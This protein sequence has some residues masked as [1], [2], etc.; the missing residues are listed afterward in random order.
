MDAEIGTVAA[1]FLFW[2]YLFRIFGIGSVQWVVLDPLFV[3]TFF[4]REDPGHHTKEGQTQN[5]REHEQLNSWR[6]WL[7]EVIK[8]DI[9]V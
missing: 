3:I 8:D 6:P 2:E 4:C 9:L 5:G 1:Q 7:V